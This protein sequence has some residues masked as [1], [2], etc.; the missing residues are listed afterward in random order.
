MLKF[1]ATKVKNILTTSNTI[2]FFN[3]W[4]VFEVFFLIFQIY[5]NRKIGQ[6][7]VVIKKCYRNHKKGYYFVY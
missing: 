3:I 1:A 2:P 7:R 4:D 5:K 6:S